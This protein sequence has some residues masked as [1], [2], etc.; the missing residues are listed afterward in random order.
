MGKTTSI[1]SN[2]SLDITNLEALAKDISIRL[3]ATICFGYEKT[4]Y[5]DDENAILYDFEFID[6]GTISFSDATDSYNL[7][8]CTYGSKEFIAQN[9]IAILEDENF[10]I[11]DYYKQ[12][13]LEEISSIEFELEKIIENDTDTICYIYQ[14]SLDIWFT[15]SLDWT[16]FQR[17]FIYYLDDNTVAFLNN[18]RIENKKL[19]SLFGGN[20][21]F[22]YSYEEFSNSIQEYL[23]NSSLEEVNEKIEI[24]FSGILV[25]IS[26]YFSAKSYLTNDKFIQEH[27]VSEKFN[28][29]RYI[30]KRK[31]NFDPSVIEYP[32]LFYDDF[33]DI[34]ELFN[35][36]S[37]FDFDYNGNHIIEILKIRRNQ[38]EKT[39]SIRPKVALPILE[40]FFKL[41][42]CLIAGFSHY[43]DGELE[44]KLIKNQEV[45]LKREPQNK[46]DK[47]AIALFIDFQNDGKFEP[48]KIGYI[49]KHENYMLS[50]LLDNQ[51][52]MKAFL[53]HISE[54]EL[55]KANYNYA[56]KISIYQRNNLG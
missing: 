17:D 20:Y 13:I 49:G 42:T 33:K 25:N 35:P 12:L 6:L 41:Y 56:L 8:D 52:E 43:M 11:D 7:I 16:S 48:K 19:I 24:V 23:M 1:I 44:L 45:F 3:Q 53:T 47:H 27:Y 10:K 5:I 39:K 32:I 21:M 22:V 15:E 18:W 31:G 29:Y 54:K 37:Y 55:D 36:T 40:D 9:G 26:N 14:K 4:W 2:H 34:D 38:Y 50:K 51:F 46:F 28:K 30:T